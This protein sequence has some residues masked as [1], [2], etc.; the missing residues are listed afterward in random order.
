MKKA[1][2]QHLSPSLRRVGEAVARWTRMFYRAQAAHQSLARLRQDE[3][4]HLQIQAAVLSDTDEG[5]ILQVLSA[6]EDSAEKHQEELIA[7]FAKYNTRMKQMA[8][9]LGHPPPG[10]VSP[11][12]LIILLWEFTA[13]YEAAAVA[14]KERASQV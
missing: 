6:F 2:P 10:P 1:E 9:F 3:S 12:Q 8:T 14:L 13:Q 7:M 11:E 5:Q 4:M